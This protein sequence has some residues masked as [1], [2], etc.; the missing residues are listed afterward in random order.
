MGQRE[1]GA[2]EYR[3]LQPEPSRERGSGMER[4]SLKEEALR[5]NLCVNGSRPFLC[6][7]YSRGSLLG[8]PPG[9]LPNRDLTHWDQA[10]VG[11]PDR[12]CPSSGR[13]AEVYDVR[14]QGQP[15]WKPGRYARGG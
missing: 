15:D 5:Y 8:P 7:S 14:R 4:V 10:R 11:L 12:A 6:G 13:A 3:S 1:L 9:F 2:K